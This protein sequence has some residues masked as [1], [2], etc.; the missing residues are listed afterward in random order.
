MR[1]T[2]RDRSRISPRS[3]GDRYGERR[4][5]AYRA[6]PRSS[7]FC[8]SRGKIFLP[9]EHSLRIATTARQ[10]S[11]VISDYRLGQATRDEAAVTSVSYRHRSKIQSTFAGVE[12]AQ[13]A[14]V[15]ELRR[16]GSF[17]FGNCFGEKIQNALYA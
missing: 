17:R 7:D 11:A 1:R 8:H 12:L 3:A 15:K 5:A 6:G 2:E 9:C 14:I 4:A 10:F 13:Q 16:R